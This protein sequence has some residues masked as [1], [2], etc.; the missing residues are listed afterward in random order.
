MYSH[1]SAT[2]RQAGGRRYVV[3]YV[4]AHYASRLGESVVRVP[5]MF[6]L[7][8]FDF[9]KDEANYLHDKF[10][11]PNLNLLVFVPLFTRSR[12]QV[13]VRL[14]SRRLAYAHTLEFLTRKTFFHDSIYPVALRT[15]H[16]RLY[17]LVTT[18]YERV[19]HPRV[20]ARNGERLNFEIF[21]RRE[22][23]CNRHDVLCPNT[24]EPRARQQRG[25][26]TSS[27]DMS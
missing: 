5:A 25:H 2:F 3:I 18:W 8:L 27:S 22:E 21:T 7:R 24:N 19:K 12:M 6:Q 26:S 9:S 10:I 13:L 16:G 17:M 14:S 20:G 23:I 15:L 11:C 4:R 1:I